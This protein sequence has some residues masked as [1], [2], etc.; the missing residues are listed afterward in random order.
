M[1]RAQRLSPED[2]R[3]A[4]I[5][6]TVPLLV[7]AG[8]DV[9]TRRIAEACGIAEGTLFRAFPTKDD[10]IEATVRACLDPGEVIAALHAIDPGEPLE[11]RLRRI[12]LLLS[13]RI[14]EISGLF[15]ALMRPRPG[16]KGAEHFHPRGHRHGPRD[17]TERDRITD[18]IAGLLAPDAERLALDPHTAASFVWSNVTA[19]THP[20]LGNGL[21]GDPDLLSHLLLKALQ[22]DPS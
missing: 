21:A 17:H 18:A 16:G 1:S 15:A 6:A 10:L 3:Q 7:A 2:R 19:A 20:M 9:S 14:H 12:V 8:P 11:A 22:K 13:D 5:T 4:I